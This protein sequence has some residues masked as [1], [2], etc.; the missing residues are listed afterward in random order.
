MTATF[1]PINHT[2]FSLDRKK[3][4]IEVT[5]PLMTS[6]DFIKEKQFLSLGWVCIGEQRMDQVLMDE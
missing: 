2:S 4:K 1:L 3:S 6:K 5:R